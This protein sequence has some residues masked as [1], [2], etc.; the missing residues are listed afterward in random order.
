MDAGL[1]SAAVIMEEAWDKV[2]TTDPEHCNKVMVGGALLSQGNAMPVRD[3]IEVPLS[4]L[5]AKHIAGG[6]YEALLSQWKKSDKIPGGALNESPC[7][8]EIGTEED[9]DVEGFRPLSISHMAGPFAIALVSTTLGLAIYFMFGYALD[10]VVALA[11]M[12]DNLGG[13]ANMI[14]QDAEVCKQMRGATFKELWDRAK[15][16]RVPNAE[17][18]AAIDAAPDKELLIQTVFKFECS[19]V[20]R[21]IISLKTYKFSTLCQLAVALK[22]NEEHFNDAVNHEK[23]PKFM[24]IKIIIEKL[25][26]NHDGV[27]SSRSI[28]LWW[29]A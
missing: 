21:K 3:A 8:E 27:T 11:D 7:N 2:L 19:E 24:I 20:R 25:D 17:L 18:A 26:V 28:R 22:V 15:A 23:S 10:D 14:A 1:C 5:L 16:A 12:A 13:G 9:D 6:T 4:Y 29:L